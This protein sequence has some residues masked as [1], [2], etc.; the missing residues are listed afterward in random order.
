MSVLS[1]P[2]VANYRQIA[3]SALQAEALQVLEKVR[4]L[5]AASTEDATSHNY[6]IDSAFRELFIELIS[7]LD[8]EHDD[9]DPVWSLL[10]S[11]NLLCDNGLCEHALGFWLVEDLLDSQT[12]N[13]CRHVF[14]YL[15]SRR[16]RMTKI[17]F[18][19]KH[20]P[21]LRCCNELLRRLSRAEDTVFCG[22]VFIYLFQSFPLGDKSSVNL[23]GEFH[24]ENVT[25]YDEL[26]LNTDA[27]DETME[28][29]QQETGIPTTTG[30]SQT[31]QKKSNLN[32]LYPIFW[33][34][35]SLFSFP[36][37]LFE[38]SSMDQFKDAIQQTLSAFRQ[39]SSNT[40]TA[41]MSDPDKRGLKR[42]RG[43]LD[44]EHAEMNASA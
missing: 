35:Q 14:H 7:T 43:N 6:A 36:T 23:R 10:D 1:V 41:A 32:D 42:K 9:F 39:V 40:T 31:I 4:R 29:E 33:S 17:N 37:K 34:L 3:E 44:T 30:S 25:I 20:L 24:V 2:L 22:R 15:E 16:E 26:P 19:Q 28:V 12:I 5:R 27:T 8:I 13:G 18:K 21:I 38:K 11:V